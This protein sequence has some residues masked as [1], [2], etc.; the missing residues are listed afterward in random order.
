MDSLTTLLF[1]IIG[2][3]I[4]IGYI[5]ISGYNRDEASGAYSW[6]SN[7]DFNRKH[8]GIV[9]TL[10][11][12]WG[13]YYKKQL[14]LTNSERDLLNEL[15][16]DVKPNPLYRIDFCEKNL[17]SL[18][19]NVYRLTPHSLPSSQA[20]HL[21][22][23]CIYGLMKKY[24]LFH[25]LSEVQQVELSK[26]E[27]ILD[28]LV[29]SEVEKNIENLPKLTKAQEK[30]LFSIDKNRWKNTF[31]GLQ[32]NYADSV[33]FYNDIKSIEA[34]NYSIVAR[35]N[36][37][38][39]SYLFMVDKDKVV[40][41]KFYIHYLN[42][43]SESKK[44]KFREISKANQKKIF[45]SEVQL[46]NFNEILKI[47][48]SKKRLNQALTAIDEVFVK[49][50]KKVV[51]DEQAIH[52]ARKDLIEVV[53]LLN[54]YLEDEEPVVMNTSHT[55]ENFSS[56]SDIAFTPVQLEFLN[57]LKMKDY[58]LL[59]D[60]INSFAN[61][62]GVFKSQLIDGINDLCYDTL[63]DMLIE[64]GDDNNY[65]LNKKYYQKIIGN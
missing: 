43:G 17:M 30:E 47:Y 14:K 26:A 57:T 64:E 6:K 16:R 22:N 46:E 49:K 3:I 9:T 58:T 48:R 52:S 33:Q 60:D 45:T 4:F 24:H 32:D 25:P 59:L 18:F 29:K 39:D 62:R 13:N 51:L 20:F 19:L 41:L 50:R 31:Q 44:F 61:S 35:R 54:E 63:D 56:S 12:G 5:V 37:Y 34:F 21:F 23:Y 65:I 1:L 2:F 15:S 38:Y 10:E 8:Q 36:L 53:D 7:L 11:I 55:V 42:V 27:T 40:A 28:D